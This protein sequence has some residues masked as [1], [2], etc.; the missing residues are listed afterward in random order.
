MIFRAVLLS[1]V[2]F[3][4]VGSSSLA[5]T[6]RDVVVLVNS[7]HPDGAAVAAR[8]QAIHDVP[9]GHVLTL[10]VEPADQMS[11]AEYVARIQ[12]PLAEWLEREAAHDRIT[13]IVL[14]PGFPV[15]IA[16]TV[17]RT[18]T[19]ASVDS[20]L[21]VLYRVLTGASVG[22]VGPVRNPYFTNAPVDG[23]WPA[24][25]RAVHDIY[26]V[27]RLD[28]FTTADVM[29]L[30]D[31]CTGA[32]PGGRFV[33]DD[34]APLDVRE[35]RW[36]ASAA[37][38]LREAVGPDR[39]VFDR[40]IPTVQGESDVMGFYSW[41]SADPGHRQRKVPLTFRPG[42]IAASL[43]STDARTFAEPP[44]TWKPG[45]WQARETFYKGSPEWL[46]GDLVRSGLS[47]VAA[48]V[49]DPYGDGAVRPDVL[50]PAY[51][52][53]RT[54][55]EA[56]Y[57]AIPSVS[58]QTVVVGD[59]L[60][61]PFGTPSSEAPTFTLHEPSGL[62]QPFFDRRLAEAEARSP[63]APRDVIETMV[64]VQSWLAR[65]RRDRVLAMLDTLV[66]AHPGFLPALQQRAQTLQADGQDQA[67]IAAYRA[68]LQASPDDM[69]ALNNLAYM[70]VD[71]PGGADEA[72]TLARRAYEVARGMGQVG[73]TFGWVLFRT[74][75]ASQAERVLRDAAA[76]Q[77]RLAE[78]RVHLAR[79][80]LAQ[81][82]VPA[83]KVEWDRA[84]ARDP[85]MRDHPQA[86]PL[87]ETFAG[88]Q[89]RP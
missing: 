82:Q 50:F 41:A 40:T 60:C 63:A 10:D 28:G 5:A 66:A 75:D 71:E 12:R 49:I 53:G 68:V 69:L 38:R 17:G 81:G 4:L 24:F 48:N 11:R 23:G 72:L 19:V 44:D 22:E 80:L 45:S 26:L 13:Y 27:T 47:G 35:H 70:L 8:Y 39:V 54:L 3:A 84:R 7:R 59:P 85:A 30:L 36:F 34:R 83:A 29:A 46:A 21:A 64:A 16:G 6:G 65:G 57:L 31:R 14:T 78:V 73:D 79:V 18:G 25:D 88:S 20:E 2:A 51:V 55:G 32:A 1:F 76:R 87:V 74:G 43:A 61:Q 56:M 37:E 9:D 89:S 33:L 52:A 15:R 58:W 77:P 67:A 86:G 62:T 42:A